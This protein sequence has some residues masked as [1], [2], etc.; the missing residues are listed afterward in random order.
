MVR[1]ALSGVGRVLREEDYYGHHA[2]TPH[3]TALISLP[4]ITTEEGQR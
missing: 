3:T 1:D 4:S 2:G